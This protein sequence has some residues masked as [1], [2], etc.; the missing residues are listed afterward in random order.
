MW[1]AISVS[2]SSP[3]AIHVEV[4]KSTVIA[5]ICSKAIV[6]EHVEKYDV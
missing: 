2:D 5:G 1:P 4:I 6:S 3:Q